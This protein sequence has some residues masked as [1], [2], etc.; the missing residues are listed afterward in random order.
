MGG[1]RE[2]ELSHDACQCQGGWV[3]I[4]NSSISF[5]L[6]QQPLATDPPLP[7]VSRPGL[8]LLSHLRATLSH[9]HLTQGGQRDE[10]RGH[11]IKPQ[12]HCLLAWP[13]NN[14]NE[15]KIQRMGRELGINLLSLFLGSPA[16]QWWR[17]PLIAA[18]GRQ[19]QRQRQR[20]VNF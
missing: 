16:G 18:L 14:S 19:R 2:K 17:T 8:P 4:Q 3:W 13:K 20:Q 10:I 5:S 15:E 11:G 6:I 7:V 12:R 9:C 1:G